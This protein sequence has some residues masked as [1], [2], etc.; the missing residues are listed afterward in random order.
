MQTRPSETPRPADGS[1]DL[2]DDMVITHLECHRVT[3]P[4]ADPP[5]RWRSGLPGSAGDADWGVVLVRTANGSEGTAICRNFAI[6]NDLVD[7]VLR[8]EVVGLN[9]NR[10]EFVWHRMWEIDRI[11]ELPIYVL[12]VVDVALWDL[13]GKFFGVPAWTLMGSFRDKIPAYASTSTFRSIEEFL[14]VADQCL[15]LGY[16]AIKLHAWGD[17][18]RDAQ[19]CARLREH[20]G[21]EVSLMYDGSAG[22]DLKDAVYVGRALA[23]SGFDWYEEPMREFNVTAYRWLSERVSVPLL[24]G[25]TSDGAHLNT[26]DFIASGC[27]TGVRTS[28]DLRGGFTGALKVAHLA[29]SFGLRAEVHGPKIPHEHLCMAIPNNTYYE[30]LV[31]SNPVRR[32]R[33]VDASGMVHAPQAPGVG[34]PPGL[35]YPAALARHVD[36]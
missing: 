22:F 18:R 15:E 6:V 20:V 26:A 35:D 23:D 10:R 27:A 25:E 17:P 16:P 11:E 13:A 1:S 28:A 7:R 31:T 5:F 32:E 19:L 24:V 36:T 2:A 3:V 14:D 30:S 21:S 33:C 4:G 9:A 12:G 29:E 8:H 34:L